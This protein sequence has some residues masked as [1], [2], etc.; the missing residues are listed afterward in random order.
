MNKYA[1]NY[2]YNFTLDVSMCNKN[3]LIIAGK[4]DIKKV[5][6]TSSARVLLIFIAHFYKTD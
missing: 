5:K 4:I 1:C 6:F 3:I 2:M